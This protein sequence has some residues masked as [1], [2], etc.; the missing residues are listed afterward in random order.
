MK[1]L[2]NYGKNKKKIKEKTEKNFH[3][4]QIIMG[5]TSMGLLHLK[6][7]EQST[8]RTVELV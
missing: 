7:T 6:W 8:G 3:Q 1:K 4:K 5:K 2:K